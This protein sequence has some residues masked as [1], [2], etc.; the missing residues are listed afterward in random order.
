MKL[1]HRVLRYAAEN[2]FVF[3]LHRSRCLKNSAKMARQHFPA[4]KTKDLLW[5]RKRRDSPSFHSRRGTDVSLSLRL[6]MLIAAGISLFEVPSNYAL[7]WRPCVSVI[8]A[9]TASRTQYHR[10]YS[11]DI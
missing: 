4:S 9:Y 10:Q 3:D 11:R 6:D 1:R 8:T 5:R 2:S 7:T